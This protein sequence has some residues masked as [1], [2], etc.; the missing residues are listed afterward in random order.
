MPCCLK[1]SLVVVGDRVQ[2]LWGRACCMSVIKIIK[3]SR[4]LVFWQMVALSGLRTGLS[5]VLAIGS[6]GVDCSAV[7]RVMV[8][9]S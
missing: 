5:G 9:C 7:G 4:Q 2:W 6:V 3:E 1:V 8:L